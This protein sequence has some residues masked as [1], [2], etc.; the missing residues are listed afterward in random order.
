MGIL[1]WRGR[2]SRA[3]FRRMFVAALQKQA[4]HLVCSDSP[5]D[6]LAVLITGMENSKQMTQWLKNAYQEFQKDPKK[7]PES[8]PDI[9]AKLELPR[10]HVAERGATLVIQT[11]T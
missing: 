1:F 2:V 5:E 10:S 9:L 3:S 4:P 6:D 11:T 7:H 8:H